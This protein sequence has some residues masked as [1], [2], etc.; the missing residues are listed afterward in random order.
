MPHA[1]GQDLRDNIAMRQTALLILFAAALPASAE[2]FDP[3][4]HG[5]F[6]V[7]P[8]EIRA[9]VHEA[10]A[11]AAAQQYAPLPAGPAPVVLRYEQACIRSAVRNLMRLP[12]TPGETEP[13]I[14]YS[15]KMTPAEFKVFQK[16]YAEQL[17]EEPDSVSNYF[18]IPGNTIYLSDRAEGYKAPY[19]MDASFAHEY[20]HYLQFKHPGYVKGD[21][22]E[23]EPE[24][25]ATAVQGWFAETF[26][27]GGAD[28]CA[29]LP[30]TP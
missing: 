1:Q 23:S 3:E 22:H 29:W 20:T 7:S 14:L 16:A 30:V 19:T 25:Q 9:L 10:E 28:P 13:I 4:I 17:G 24:P 8:E 5:F 27:A 15:S 18:H 6:G 21:D 12:K 2:T 11:E 26:V